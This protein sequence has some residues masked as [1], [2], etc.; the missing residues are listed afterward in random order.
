MLAV[1]QQIHVKN[2]RSFFRRLHN[3]DCA[4]LS[5]DCTSIGTNSANSVVTFSRI[6]LSTH[7]VIALAIVPVTSSPKLSKIPENSAS[8]MAGW[9]ELLIH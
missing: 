6:T 4:N 5:V 2:I 9:R 3:Q 7:S 8:V 1:S